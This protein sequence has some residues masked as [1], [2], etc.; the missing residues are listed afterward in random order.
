MN[1]KD[2]QSIIDNYNEKFN[3]YINFTAK[4]QAIR[5]LYLENKPCNLAEYFYFFKTFSNFD[6]SSMVTCLEHNFKLSR[7]TARKI[8][9]ICLNWILSGYYPSAKAQYKGELNNDNN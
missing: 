2:L 6:N 8:T 1:N 4:N 7:N 9:K 3:N 5:E